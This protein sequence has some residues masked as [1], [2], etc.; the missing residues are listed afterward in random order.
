MFFLQAPEPSDSWSEPLD[1]TKDGPVCIQKNYFFANP[2]VE[3]QEDC[4]YINVYA[5]KVGGPFFLQF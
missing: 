3:G 4:L 5:P 1:A 2:K